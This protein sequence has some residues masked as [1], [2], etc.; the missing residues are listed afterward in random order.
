[1]NLRILGALLIIAACGGFG[2]L[3]AANYKREEKSLRQL[4]SALDYMECELQYRQ[5]PLPILCRN[6]SQNSSHAL[7][8]LLQILADELSCHTAPNVNS[9]MRSA[10]RKVINMPS[11]THEALVNLGQTLGQFDLDGQLKGIQ[12]VRTSSK[13]Y[14]EALMQNQSARLRSYQTL[15][16]CAGAA[17]VILFI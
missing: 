9:C 17:I 12:S 15:G 7:K 13:L 6:A 3:I 8:S 1:M 10:L 5:T 16:L 11:L 14:L 2:F 4:I